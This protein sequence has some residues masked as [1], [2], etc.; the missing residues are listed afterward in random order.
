MWMSIVANRQNVCALLTPHALF[1]EKV[2]HGHEYFYRL[3]ML[4]PRLKQF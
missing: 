2:D 1:S 3:N 4:S